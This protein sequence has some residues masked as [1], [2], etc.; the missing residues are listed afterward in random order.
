MARP[1]RVRNP[2]GNEPTSPGAAP[3]SP[4][5]QG[6]RLGTHRGAGPTTCRNC[7]HWGPVAFDRA[8]VLSD[9]HNAAQNAIHDLKFNGNNKMGILLGELLAP[10]IRPARIDVLIPVPLHAARRRERGFDQA[11]VL[12]RGAARELGV[13]VEAGCLRRIRP[14]RAQSRQGAPAAR[15]ANLRDAFR[16]RRSL[17]DGSATVGLVDDVLT[18]GATLSAAAA[19]L[20]LVHP[21]PIVALAVA[22]P[23]VGGRP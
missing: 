7:H 14:T 16:A 21:G 19:A 6:D 2:V 22:S 5:C 3:S 17:A 12:A 8:I 15:V 23:F 18:T 4:T 20:R 11:E 10:Q 13:D 9:F 1:T